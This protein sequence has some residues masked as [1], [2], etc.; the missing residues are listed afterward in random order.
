M[1]F[2][3]NVVSAHILLKEIKEIEPSEKEICMEVVLV[4]LSSIPIPLVS[5]ITTFTD[6]GKEL[7]K[8]NDFFQKLVI[9]Y[10]KI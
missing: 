4:G 3:N 2:I 7:K 8:Y 6:V 9:F 10:T 1:K 5:I